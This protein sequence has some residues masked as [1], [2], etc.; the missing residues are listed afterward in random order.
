MAYAFTR[1]WEIIY[2]WNR[3]KWVYVDTQKS[4]KTERPCI[5]CKQMPTKEGYD[6]C[7]GKLDGVKNACCGHGVEGRYIQYIN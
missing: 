6:A 1:G 5:R 2:D 3:Q 7:L 4:I